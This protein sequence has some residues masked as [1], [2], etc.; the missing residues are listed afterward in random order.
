MVC[1]GKRLGVSF[2]P[3]ESVILRYVVGLEYEN[4]GD[5]YKLIGKNS[6]RE[7]AKQGV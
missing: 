7:S 5:R 1:L 4:I 6:Q 2:G 3:Q